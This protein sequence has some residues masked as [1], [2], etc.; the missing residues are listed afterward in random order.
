MSGYGTDILLWSERQADLLRRRAAGDLVNDTELDWANIAE[1][2]ADVGASQLAQV[3][4]LLR[5]APLA[6]AR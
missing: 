2:I 4:S 1:E 6:G 5:Q 3:R